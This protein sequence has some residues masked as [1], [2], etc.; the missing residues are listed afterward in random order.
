MIAAPGK[1]S[2]ERRPTWLS[3]IPVRH[4]RVCLHSQAENTSL[5]HASASDAKS[6]SFVDTSLLLEP[7]LVLYASSRRVR[8]REVQYAYMLRSVAIR[9]LCGI[10]RIHVY[11]VY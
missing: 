4:A 7:M 9:F 3:S 11:D 10:E 6:R 5:A 2:G 1:K 8:V